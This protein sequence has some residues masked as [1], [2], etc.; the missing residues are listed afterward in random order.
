MTAV[1]IGC[2]E[3]APAVALQADPPVQGDAGEEYM[4]LHA[5]MGQPFFNRVAM[6]E[7]APSAELVQE[8]EANAD[9]I[10]RLAYATRMDACDWGVPDDFDMQT[11]LP[12]LGKVR[13]LARTLNVDARR[14]AA[15]GDADRASRRVAG[16]VRLAHHAAESGADTI[17][18]WL[19]GIAV[20]NLAT[21]A[22]VYCAPDFDADQRRRVLAELQQIDTDDPYDLKSKLAIDRERSQDVGVAP[23]D[24]D[25]VQKAAAKTKGEIERAVAALQDPS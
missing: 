16:L 5:A 2:G 15:S 18:E 8:L 10:D 24:E 20:L 17:I 23:A 3:Q 19:V 1:L 12:H 21:D 6:V 22:A 13:A 11:M 25:G 4:S 9:L 7:G 14:L